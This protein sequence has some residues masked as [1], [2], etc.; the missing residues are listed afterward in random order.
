M[1]WMM[2]VEVRALSQFMSLLWLRHL[3]VQIPLSTTGRYEEGGD[4]V[5]GGGTVTKQALQNRP[6]G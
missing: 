6:Y 5:L 1:L 3:L 4:N 2:K